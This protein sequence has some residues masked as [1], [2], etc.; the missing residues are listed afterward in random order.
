MADTTDK[1]MLEMLS[2]RAEDNRKNTPE[3]K[4]SYVA[5]QNRP[6]PRRRTDTKSSASASSYPESPT[7]HAKI[8]SRND[9]TRTETR[10]ALWSTLHRQRRLLLGAVSSFHIA[11][12]QTHSCPRERPPR[13]VPGPREDHSLRWY[14][15]VQWI[16]QNTARKI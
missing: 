14:G 4:N 1:P 13:H 16:I 11:T 3:K 5:G 10:K 2:N 7:R 15:S 8:V 6:L 12:G 9:G